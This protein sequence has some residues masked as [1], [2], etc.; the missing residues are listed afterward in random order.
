MADAAQYL[1]FSNRPRRD[2]TAVTSD[3]RAAVAGLIEEAARIT[4]GRP[5][6]ALLAG[7]FLHT[8]G[9]TDDA[10]AE[11]TTPERLAATARAVRAGK[12]RSIRIL[13]R[14]TEA[15]LRLAA[16]AGEEPIIGFDVSGA[17]ALARAGTAPFE[18]RAVISGHTVRAS[19]AGWEFGRGPV[20]EAP[21]LTIL[22]FLLCVGDE[23]PRRPPSER[24]R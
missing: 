22:S 19:D 13:A 2:E 1:P 5:D 10:P 3:R 20:L 15:L 11:G 16:A 8:S 4:A 17:V 14:T 12:R 24:R 9:L 6:A 7:A 21:A 18:R 23:P